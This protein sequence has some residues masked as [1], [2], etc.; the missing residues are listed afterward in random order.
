LLYWN[1]EYFLD[2]NRKEK[3]TIAQPD[4]SSSCSS[5]AKS[6]KMIDQ[7]SFFTDSLAPSLTSYV[8]EEIALPHFI[9]TQAK[10]WLGGNKEAK[11]VV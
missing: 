3:T 1:D 11:C 10:W 8:I 9:A 7:C 6:E 2:R 4:L 5:S